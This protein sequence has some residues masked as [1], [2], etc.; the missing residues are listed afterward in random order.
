LLRPHLSERYP[1]PQG[2]LAISQLAKRRAK[3]KVVVM[4]DSVT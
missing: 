4:I 2:A 3:G 1:L